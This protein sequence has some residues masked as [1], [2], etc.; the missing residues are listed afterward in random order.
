ML[1]KT[2]LKMA[3]LGPLCAAATVAGAAE[4]TANLSVSALVLDSC[5]LTAAT[6]LSFATIDSANASNEVT[7][8][9]IVVLCTGNR[10]GASVA[11][12]GGDNFSGGTRKMVSTSGDLLPYS[13]YSDAGRSSAIASGGAVFSGNLS[14]VVPQVIPVYGQIPAGSYSAGLYT[15]TILVTLTH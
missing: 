1:K 2:S 6:A 7:P 5:T 13:I 8:G 14:A 12:S 15:D 11:L 3:L 4:E 10:T 9:S